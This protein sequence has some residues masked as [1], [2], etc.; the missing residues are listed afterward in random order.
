[1]PASAA[2]QTLG[3]G[4]DSLVGGPALDLM[5]PGLA[6]NRL[7]ATLGEGTTAGRPAAKTGWFAVPG[8]AAGSEDTSDGDD[9]DVIGPTP[10]ALDALF[11]AMG[12]Q[13]DTLLRDDAGD[14]ED[15]SD[16]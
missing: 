9:R 8:A 1:L 6:V 7:A 14:W 16:D 13:A 15:F 5:L 3:R 12:D 11:A 10:E 4:D 2:F